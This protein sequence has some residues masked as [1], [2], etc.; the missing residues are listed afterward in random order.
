MAISNINRVKYKKASLAVVVVVSVILGV[1]YIVANYGFLSVNVSNSLPQWFFII[2][3]EKN[4]FKEGDL[5]AYPRV[6]QGIDKTLIKVI[7]GKPLDLISI[8]DKGVYI[9]NKL[10]GYILPQRSNGK[11]LHPIEGGVIP[12]NKYFAWTPHPKSFDSRYKEMGLVD[13]DEIIG[14]AYIINWYLFWKIVIGGC[15]V[16]RYRRKIIIFLRRCIIKK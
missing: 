10:I 5:I 3:K 2:S 6:I 4:N 7:A 16:C 1:N 8:K 14:R 11:K 12:K 13:Y 15:L 9:N